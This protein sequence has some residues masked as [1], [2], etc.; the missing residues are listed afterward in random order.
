MIAV[1]CREKKRHG[2]APMPR[3][4]ARASV[5]ECVRVCGAQAA[6]QGVHGGRTKHEIGDDQPPKKPD[7]CDCAVRGL[8][9]VVLRVDNSQ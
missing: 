9:V 4:V 1:L 6:K 7:E 5:C 8:V 2:L 3:T